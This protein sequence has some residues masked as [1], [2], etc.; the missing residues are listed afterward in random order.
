MCSSDLTCVPETEM[1]SRLMA[2][3]VRDGIVADAGPNLHFSMM[4]NDVLDI[5]GDPLQ[6]FSPRAFRAIHE[7]QHLMVVLLILLRPDD[8]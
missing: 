3:Q 5:S 2:C 7:M 1:N 8:S 4:R 6:G